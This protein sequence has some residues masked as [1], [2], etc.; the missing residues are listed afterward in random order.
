VTPATDAV[1]VAACVHRLAVLLQAGLAPARAWQLVA[2][3]APYAPAAEGLAGA[4][5][6]D[7]PADGPGLSAELA[8]RGGAWEHVAVAWTVAATVGAPLSDSLRGIADALRDAEQA[9]DDVAV[10]LA[11]PAT[12]ARLI[13]W[14]PLL[15]VALVAGFG[16]DVL[17]TLTHPVGVACLVLGVLLMIGARRWTG[18]LVRRAQP[19]PGVAGWECDVMAIALRGGVSIERA[20]EVV[21]D[22]G[23]PGARAETAGILELSRASGAPA[24]EL[25]RAEAVDRRRAA[26][27]EGRLRAARLSGRLL[28]PL[29][30]CTLPSFLLL[31]VAPMLLSVLSTAPIVF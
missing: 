30:V 24:I 2:A 22:A 31:G 13:A 8:R 15:A 11:E 14:L 25:L 29:G 23:C 28:I 27:T 4:P 12:T 21:A 16:F 9:R 6:A 18:A 19:E 5:S 20:L 3:E 26:R 10:A 1:T 7:R 17:S